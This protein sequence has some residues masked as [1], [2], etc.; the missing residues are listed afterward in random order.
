MYS[1]SSLNISEKCTRYL[2]YKVCKTSS[3]PLKTLYLMTVIALVQY[4]PSLTPVP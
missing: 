1:F 2:G 4:L 3:L